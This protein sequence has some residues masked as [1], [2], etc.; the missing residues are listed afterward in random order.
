MIFLIRNN[1]TLVKG[2][3][4][5]TSSVNWA[6]TTDPG[7]SQKIKRRDFATIELAA[8]FLNSL[9]VSDDDIDSALIAMYTLGHTRAVFRDLKFEYSQDY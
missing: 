9:N 1:T 7:S 2:R 8:E 5:D 4:E 3:P 6:V